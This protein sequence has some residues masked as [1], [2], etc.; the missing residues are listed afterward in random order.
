MPRT[1]PSRTDQELIRALASRGVSI[2]ATQLERWRSKSYLPRHLRQGLG[3]GAGS[4]SAPVAGLHDYVE[5]L[6][7]RAGQGRS[8]DEA[9]LALFMAGLLQ[10]RNIPCV[11]EL[12]ATHIASVRRALNKWI[13]SGDR[14]RDRISRRASDGNYTESALDEAYSEAEKVSNR[15]TSKAKVAFDRIGAELSGTAPSTRGEIKT[16]EEKAYLS[17]AQLRPSLWGDDDEGERANIWDTGLTPLDA[18]IFRNECQICASR[19]KHFAGSLIGQREILRS[20]CFCEINRA[21]AIGGSISMLVA[22]VRDAAHAD[23]GDSFARAAVQLIANTA[24]RFLLRDI[25]NI[26]PDRPTSVAAC[27]L[28]FLHD[29]RL[30]K[31]AAATLMQLAIWKIESAK[32]TSVVVSAARAMDEVLHKPSLLRSADG[33]GVLL[34]LDGTLESDELLRS[35][36]AHCHSSCIDHVYASAI[37][38][39]S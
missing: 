1:Q 29:C 4:R 3:R 38:H 39:G 28:F 8:T 16:A 23:P 35:H 13:D 12:T 19:T 33:I 36:S 11:N 31:S 37:R 2:T 7:L 20:A 9:V 32:D 18:S 30:L 22:S 34:A 17:A 26:S 10:P 6:A 27:T 14:D 5:S 21:R 15:R 24:F 25:A